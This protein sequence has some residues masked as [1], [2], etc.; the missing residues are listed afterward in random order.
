MIG[1]DTAE[2]LCDATHGGEDCLLP[3]EIDDQGNPCNG[4]GKCE[5]DGKCGCDDGFLGG[6]CE[7]ECPVKDKQVCA[8]HGK[9]VV[10][11]PETEDGPPAVNCDCHRGFMGPECHLEC[12]TNPEGVVCAG[13]GKCDVD[14]GHAV[15]KCETG[16][17]G[18]NCQFVCPG[19]LSSD[20]VC[21]GHG[22]CHAHPADTPIGAVCTACDEGYVGTDCSLRCP[23]I[24]Q[25]GRPCGGNGK[26]METSGRATCVCEEGFLGDGCEYDCP[27]DRAG[28]PCA[29][30]GQC[31]LWVLKPSVS[32][33]KVI[34]AKIATSCA[35]HIQK[36]KQ[37][38]QAT[39]NV[40]L[41]QMVP[42]Q[43]ASASR[44]SLDAAAT[45]DAL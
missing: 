10:A 34:S 17:R 3:C 38:A 44:V 29:A 39:A 13:R 5:G 26:C 12:P 22:E 28:R 21:S 33:K 37:F 7:F 15:C 27:R 23:N 35:L 41:G 8:S 42:K 40:K 25:K 6:A 36:P 9:C 45:K 43:T 24:D 11:A 32:A 18:D 20:H 1:I 4:H 2:C 19:S 31:S 14:G 16:A 30:S